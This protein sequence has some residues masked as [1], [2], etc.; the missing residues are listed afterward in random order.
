MGFGLSKLFLP[1]V[2]EDE[3]NM[4]RYLADLKANKFRDLWNLGVLES[5]SWNLVKMTQSPNAIFLGA[6][7]SGKSVA[8]NFSILTWMLANSDQTVLFIA[9][10]LKG[11]NDYQALFDYPQV[12]PVLSS[13]AGIHR[14]IDLIYDEAMARREAFNE[15]QAENIHEYEKKMKKKTGN[16]NFKLARCVLLM[17]EFHS[18]PY[19]ILNFDKDFK[20]PNT[21]AFKFHQIMRIGRS[22]G[23][24]VVACSQKGTKSDVPPEVIPNFTQK[25]IFRVNRNEAA[26]FLSDTKA[27]DIRS[28]QKGRCETDYGTCQFPYV[29]MST[30]EK[31]LKKYMKPLDA[32]CAYLTPKLIEDYLGGRSTEELYRLKKL[33]D[34]IEGIESYDADLVVSMLH[35]KLGHKVTQVD[36][37]I[38]PFGISLV[39]DW[40]NKG[41]IAVMI[42]AGAKKITGKHLH[43]LSKGMQNMGCDRG[44]LY[45][46]AEDLP[47]AVYKNAIDL[48]I[49][50]VDHED[51]LRLARQIEAKVKAI[52]ELDPSKLADEGK[53]NGDYQIKNKINDD[54]FD[55]NAYEAEDEVESPSPD[56]LKEEDKVVDSNPVKPSFI[57][58]VEEEELTQNPEIEENESLDEDEELSKAKQTLQDLLG[59][60]EEDE[61]VDAEKKL[62]ELENKT[63]VDKQKDEIQKQFDT[64][65]ETAL[66]APVQLNIKPV[67]R[68]PVRG[69]F[70]LKS[71]EAPELLV[72]LQKNTSGDVY[73]VLF[74]VMVNK[75]VIHKYFIDRQVQG[76][77]DV[78][79]RARL[80]IVS[81]A[82]WNSQKDDVNNRTVLG[83]GEFEKEISSYLDNFH[84]YEMG[85][86]KAICWSED[87]VF[88]KN[89]L[90]KSRHMDLNPTV[91]EEMAQVYGMDGD[92]DFLLAQN[93]LNIKRQDIFTPIEI[94]LQIWKMISP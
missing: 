51:M 41:K 83:S 77:F 73:R 88:V 60:N 62:E 31:L 26:Y 49:E 78:K 76:D 84:Q 19:N 11:A 66:I 30:Q 92:R 52:E 16:P 50:V 74:Y 28:D 94:D 1:T 55:P 13:E 44:I 91:F 29:P 10:T 23:T 63:E 22:F 85:M 8:A 5:R 53:E 46:S 12:Y 81:T 25:Q 89:L 18:I 21:S 33:P 20:I 57:K 9:D 27:A 67:K 32:E 75:Q 93:S 2:K 6:M 38:D 45:T 34:L 37:K 43:K 36:S 48:K 79:D 87:L 4:K 3:F 17:E 42:R 47:Q 82:E 14:V 72:H 40:P 80:S 59:E 69:Q 24:W 90:S 65:M 39:V 58:D 35:K 71:D 56:P 70:F 54:E 15:V 64:S 68:V 7:G 86:V 61:E